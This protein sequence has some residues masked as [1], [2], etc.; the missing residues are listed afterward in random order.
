[1]VPELSMSSELDYGHWETVIFHAFIWTVL[2]L[3]LI[4]PRTPRE[5]GAFAVLAIFLIE[6][7]IELYGFP[8]T[9]TLFSDW[10]P[11]YPTADLLSHRA[12]DLWRILLRMDDRY[13]ALDHFHLGG[14]ILIFGGLG[15]LFYASIVLRQAQDSGVPATTGP[16]AW[17][18]HPQY[19]ALFSIMLGFLV[20]GPTLL[21]LVLFPILVYLY[22]RLARREE[23]E[24]LAKFGQAY[25]I[26]MKRTPRFVG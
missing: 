3:A 17:A 14:G 24:T 5:L 7:F 22:V 15:L 21:I 16:Y 8:F 19:L 2:V 9:L 11:Y 6:E 20:Q 13:E 10:L 12:G 1:M 26:Y 18:R 25:A 4:R 23:Q